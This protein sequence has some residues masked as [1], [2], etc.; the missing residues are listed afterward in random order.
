MG[1]SREGCQPYLLNLLCVL[2]CQGAF[3]LGGQD[4]VERH[5]L[6]AGSYEGTPP[7]RTAG[8]VDRSIRGQHHKGCVSRILGQTPPAGSFMRPV[9]DV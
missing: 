6:V 1:A 3:G 8:G 4:W 9:G 7:W 5:R 2:F